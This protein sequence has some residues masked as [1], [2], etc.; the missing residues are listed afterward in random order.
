ML[1]CLYQLHPE[2]SLMLV[3]RYQLRPEV[4]F[5]LV[6]PYQLHPEVHHRRL[7]SL[8]ILTVCFCHHH[9]LSRSLVKI[10]GR[11][12]V[13]FSI[14]RIVL[15]DEPACKFSSSGVLGLEFMV[16]TSPFECLSLVSSVGEQGP[17]LLWHYLVSV[18]VTTESVY[19][20]KSDSLAVISLGHLRG[21]RAM[22]LPRLWLVQ[23]G[24]LPSS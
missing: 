24:F 21:W 5:M 12:F 6:C 22:F 2:V 23:G 19:P 14:R 17:L 15:S 10:T 1:V 18:A 4:T 9:L 11:Y 16:W 7:S 3:C 13:L 20:H 8:L